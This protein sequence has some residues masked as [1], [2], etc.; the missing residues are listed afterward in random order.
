MILNDKIEF[1]VNRDVKTAF[2]KEAK[3]TGRPYQILLRELMVALIE[4]QVRILDKIPRA[5]YKEKLK[6]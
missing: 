5:L 6:K 3:R 2:I 4:D 1:R